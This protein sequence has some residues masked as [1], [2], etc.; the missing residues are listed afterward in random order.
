MY[1]PKKSKPRHETVEYKCPGCG[2]IAS[3]TGTK[4]LN[5]TWLKQIEGTYCPDCVK[6]GKLR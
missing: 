6:N 5:D 3:Q 4:T 2:A 1:Q